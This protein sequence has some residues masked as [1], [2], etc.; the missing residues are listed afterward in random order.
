MKN[1]VAAYDLASCQVGPLETNCYCLADAVS[2]KAVIID[3]GASP[4]IIEDII[5][6]GRMLPAVIAL[7]HGHYDHT[8]AAA[9]LKKR[10]GVPLYIHRA[11]RPFLSDPMLN[12]AGLFGLRV[13]TVKADRLLDDGDTFTVGKMTFSVIHTPGHTPGGMCLRMDDLLFTGDTLFCGTV[14]RSDLE[15]GD[16]ETLVNSLKVFKTLP[17]T[18][19]ILPGH[20]AACVLS[21]ELRHNPCL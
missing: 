5:E 4:E 16:E 6:R 2:R 19:R 10:Y 20:G 7:T 1:T 8:G 13:E 21:K 18:L 15:G 3:P 14:G 11:D 17:G 12:G 9:A